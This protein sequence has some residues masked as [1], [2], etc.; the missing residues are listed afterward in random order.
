MRTGRPQRADRPLTSSTADARPMQFGSQQ[1]GA[2]G[3]GR[4]GDRHGHRHGPGSQERQDRLGG[5]RFRHAWS[6]RPES[7]RVGETAEGRNLV[8]EPPHL[9][10]Q[11][12]NTRGSEEVKAQ[13][14][15]RVTWQIESVSDSCRL[16]VVHDQVPASANVKLLGG[17]PMIISRLRTLRPANC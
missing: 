16:T 10:V 3:H 7:S 17:W 11:S 2:T 15:T 1:T 12:F 14:T 4:P 5:V 8:V 6:S 9:L 13:G